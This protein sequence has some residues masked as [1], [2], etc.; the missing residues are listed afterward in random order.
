MDKAFIAGKEQ[1]VIRIPLIEKES[2]IANGNAIKAY[3]SE[4]PFIYAEYDS[5]PREI[6]LIQSD[7]P[8]A[9]ENFFISIRDEAGNR[10]T[11][12]ICVPS[13]DSPQ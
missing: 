8:K 4:N 12:E 13:P 3:S 1:Q 6:V 11:F 10:K 9:G 5:E 7:L 2:G